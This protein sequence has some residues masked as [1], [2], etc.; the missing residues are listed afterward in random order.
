[1]SEAITLSRVDPDKGKTVLKT[2]RISESLARSLEKVAT[3]NGTSVNAY[4]NAVINRHFHWDKGAAEF[5]LI[6][7][8]SAFFMGLLEA[9]DDETLVRIGREILAPRWKEMSEFFLQDS[10]PD[11]ILDFLTMRSRINPDKLRTTITKDEDNYAIVCHHDFGPKLSIALKSAIQELVRQSFHTE[12]RMTA[13][14]S[15]VTA[16]FKVKPRNSSA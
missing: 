10:S 15:V 7:L 5:G 13:G 12:P 3:D 6:T 9:L 8:D 16:Y 1:M 2:I 14:R 4:I 11:R